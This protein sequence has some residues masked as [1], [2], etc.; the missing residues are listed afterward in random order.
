MLFLKGDAQGSA[1]L[2]LSDDALH[3]INHFLLDLGIEISDLLGPF[4]EKFGRG[5]FLSKPP[6]L[7]HLIQVYL[8]F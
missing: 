8:Q 6:L 1:L 2:D 7:L 4:G 5:A 3:E